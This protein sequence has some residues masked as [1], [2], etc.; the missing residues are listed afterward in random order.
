VPAAPTVVVMPRW[1]GSEGL[2]QRLGQERAAGLDGILLDRAL[3]AVEGV[4]PDELL[5]PDRLGDEDL[6]ASLSTAADRAWGTGEDRGPLVVVWPDLPR[7]RPAH[8]DAALSDLAEGCDLSL[9]PVFDGGFYLLALARP[10][11][12]LLDLAV[13]SW[14]SPEAMTM[15]FTLAAKDHVEVGLL[16]AER[17][18]RTPA[19]VAALIADPLTDGVLQQVLS[20]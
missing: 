16:R 8:L 7:W 5:R 3:A 15:A 9:G 1:T 17:A 12:G 14:H 13:E 6:A 18:L 11:P 19:D 2:V 4:A 20:G 10:L